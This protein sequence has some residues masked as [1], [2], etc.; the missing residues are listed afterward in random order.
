M[1][2][3]RY[4]WLSA[5]K[6][7]LAETKDQYFKGVKLSGSVDAP[8]LAKHR[9]SLT[10]NLNNSFESRFVDAKAAV[11]D[12]NRNDALAEWDMLKSDL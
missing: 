8:N 2:M 10:N 1:W 4:R 9:V 7:Y 11:V 12:I 3:R 6:T 5:T